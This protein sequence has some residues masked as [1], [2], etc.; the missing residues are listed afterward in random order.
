MDN[1][2]PEEQKKQ[3]QREASRKYTQSEKGRA[4]QA[5]HRQTE[6]YREMQARWRE[7]GGSSREYI[8]NKDRYLDYFFRKKYGITLAEYHQ[9][10]ETQHHCCYICGKPESDN[11]RQ[12]AV[13]HCHNTGKVRKLLCHHCNAALGHVEED[14]ETLQKM[15][16]YIEEHNV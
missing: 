11:G 4:N 12:L 9:M 3:R 1:L 14:L 5:K 10:N 7:T 15:I 13:D 8:R 16:S 2:T 6:S